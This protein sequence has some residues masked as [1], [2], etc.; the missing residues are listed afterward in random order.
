MNSELDSPEMTP[1]QLRR[2]ST[3][4]RRWRLLA[5]TLWSGFLGA[6]LSLLAVL[7]SWEA[8]RALASQPDFG[9]LGAIFLIAWLICA[10]TALVSQSLAAEP[11]ARL[12]PEE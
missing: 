2:E 1:E 11:K 3:W 9:V 7:M 12:G 10:I 5:V 6:T 8:M 4:P